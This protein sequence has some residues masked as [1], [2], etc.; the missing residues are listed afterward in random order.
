MIIIY[1]GRKG[2]GKTLTLVKDAYFYYLKG[3]K[4]LSNMQD[5]QFGET[6]NPKDLFNNNFLK[7]LKNTVL[8]I[9]EIQHFFDSRRSM[10]KKNIDFT[11]FLQQIRKNNIRLLGSIQ[12][13]GNV[14]LR[15]RE[16]LDILV[17]PNHIKDFG[18]CEALYIDET[19]IEDGDL[20][21]ILKSEIKIIFDAKPI[22]KLYNTR[23]QIILDKV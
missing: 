6:F 9:D 14:D 21:N 19:S 13:I 17:F 11:H 20:G 8:V 2:R 5:L 23:E 1:V 16:Q 7:E 12:R 10:S 4:I 3:W 22:Y 15:V 18:I